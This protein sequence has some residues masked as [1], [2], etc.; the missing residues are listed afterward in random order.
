MWQ[1]NCL[2]IYKVWRIAELL[3]IPVRKEDSKTRQ[4]IDY[5]NDQVCNI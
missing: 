5:E 3:H 1:R 2:I 4:N